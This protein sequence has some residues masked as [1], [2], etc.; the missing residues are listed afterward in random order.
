MV[1]INTGQ[2]LRLF[3]K[4][5]PS[6]DSTL[7]GTTTDIAVTLLPGDE[8]HSCRAAEVGIYPPTDRRSEWSYDFVGEV[9]GIEDDHFLLDSGVGTVVVGI[10]EAIASFF[11]TEA[12]T[13]GD[14]LFVPALRTDIFDR[15][16][17]SDRSY[18]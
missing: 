17:S 4:H 1:R 5:A 2:T 3:D 18:Q 8:L 6:L 15:L 11:E 12:V 7:I 16:E 13:A 14:V 10:H 9:V